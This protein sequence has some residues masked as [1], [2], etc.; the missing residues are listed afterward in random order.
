MEVYVPKQRKQIA[1]Y[2]KEAI[3]LNAL[4]QLEAESRGN[5][6]MKMPAFFEI[7][8]KRLENHLSDAARARYHEI[9]KQQEVPVGDN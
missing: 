3:R 5:S 1:V 2:S 8:V 4:A 9:L 7:T 6:E